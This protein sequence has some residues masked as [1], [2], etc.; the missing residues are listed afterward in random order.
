M[1]NRKLMRL[2][3]HIGL[4]VHS[5]SDFRGRHPACTCWRAGIND[6]E[7]LSVYPPLAFKNNWPVSRATVRHSDKFRSEFR[8]RPP[9]CTCWRA[10]INDGEPLSVYPPLAF[11]NNWPVSRA[12]VR[13]SDK[14]IVGAAPNDHPISCLGRIGRLLDRS[15]GSIR[16]AGIRVVRLRVLII[17]IICCRS[18][19]SGCD[20]QRRAVITC[21]RFRRRITYA[22][23]SRDVC[24]ISLPLISQ[25]CSACRC[26][27]ECCSLSCGDCYIR[28]LCADR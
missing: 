10:G 1:I 2:K 20:S 28:R 11:K 25:W 21:G 23:G 13:N 6:G 4:L 14:F 24:A 22:G 18:L 12:T 16:C 17:Y 5:S 15:P 3:R 7:P 9:A 26:D 27:G 8:G 19:L